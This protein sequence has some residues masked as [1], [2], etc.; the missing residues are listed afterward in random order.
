MIKHTNYQVIS[1]KNFF[2]RRNIISVMFYFFHFTK[3]GKGDF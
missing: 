3:K 2:S 1:S